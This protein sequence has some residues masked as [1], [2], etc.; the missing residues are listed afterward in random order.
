MDKLRPTSSD[1]TPLEDRYA[2]YKTA[3]DKRDEQER[4][5]SSVP[6]ISMIDFGSY[7]SSIRAGVWHWGVARIEAYFVTKLTEQFPALQVDGR[8]I[9]SVNDFVNWIKIGPWNKEMRAVVFFAQDEMWGGGNNQWACNLE[10]EFCSLFRIKFTGKRSNGSRQKRQT[11]GNCCAALFVKAKGSAIVDKIRNCTR[12]AHKEALYS[13]NEKMKVSEPISLA[14]N[15]SA[16]KSSVPKVLMREE[17]SLEVHGFI[18]KIGF[19]DGHERFHAPAMVSEN[20]AISVFTPITHSVHSVVTDGSTSTGSTSLSPDQ[21]D[22]LRGVLEGDT[23]TTEQMLKMR[24]LFGF[25]SVKTPLQPKTPIGGNQ[26]IGLKD[27]GTP[28]KRNGSKHRSKAKAKKP[29]ANKA[30]KPAANKKSKKKGTAIVVSA[31]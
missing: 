21:M 27:D 18:G 8:D 13:R 3:L 30:K 25:S 17:A 1:P 4:Q 26:P 31:W 9:E 7:L 22:L 6:K 29:A 12:R 10:R 24:M 11:K 2:H 20:D 15:E 23:P 28:V 19:C 16:K 5:S 14:E